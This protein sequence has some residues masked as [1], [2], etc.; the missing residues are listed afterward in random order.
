MAAVA[1]RAHPNSVFELAEQT[2]FTMSSGKRK[3]LHLPIST[4]CWS[5]SKGPQVAPLDGWRNRAVRD[6]VTRVSLV[7]LE[8]SERRLVGVPCLLAI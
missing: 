8:L 3:I 4:G 2:M 5:R 7:R 1:R 6:M